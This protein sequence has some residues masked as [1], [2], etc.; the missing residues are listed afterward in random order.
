MS[1]VAE[2]VGRSYTSRDIIITNKLK[3]I[4]KFPISRVLNREY[5]NFF[6]IVRLVDVIS[7]DE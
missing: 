2:F 4:Y 7:F 1:P 5:A 6:G 3:E